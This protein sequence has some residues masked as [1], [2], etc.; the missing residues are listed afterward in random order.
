MNWISVK[1][2]CSFMKS[3]KIIMAKVWSWSYFAV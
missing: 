2:V 1:F 3:M